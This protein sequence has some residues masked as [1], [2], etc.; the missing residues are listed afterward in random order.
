MLTQRYSYIQAKLRI[1]LINSNIERFCNYKR[2]VIKTCNKQII[3]Y[4]CNNSEIRRWKDLSAFAPLAGFFYV[5]YQ[6]KS[7]IPYPTNLFPL[8]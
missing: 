5:N 3:Y 7:L 4:L 1:R 8:L 2:N 6:G